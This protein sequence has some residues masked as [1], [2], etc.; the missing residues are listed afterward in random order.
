MSKPKKSLA[1][2]GGRISKTND[3]L[4]VHVSFGKIV[5]AFA[6]RYRF[7][8]L[9]S[10]LN[11][12]ESSIEDYLLPD[13]II[14]IPQPNWKSTIDSLKH[15]SAIKTSYQK[16]ISLADHVFI[17]GNPVA[18]TLA[19]YKYCAKYNRPVCHWLVGNPM[20]LLQSHS[21]SSFIKNILGQLFIWQ[22][23]KK[24][25]LGRFL[26]NGTFIC[27]GQEI[28]NRYRSAKTYT[29]IST[30]LTKNDFFER[31]DTCQG[32]TLT[33]LCLCFIRPEKGVEYLIEALHFIQSEKSINLILAGSRVR[34]PEYQTQLDTLI[35]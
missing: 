16:A 6:K 34:Y 7:I 2:I 15:L 11:T 28:A 14:L 19:L 9:C 27:N 17:R 35:K 8:Y 31:E 32:E 10:P 12:D 24:L 23:E 33:L 4:F 21:R 18:A 5:E 30:T 13:N 3:G 22:W 26:A 25:I 29:I 20:A 1:I